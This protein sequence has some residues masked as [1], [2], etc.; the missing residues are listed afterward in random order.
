MSKQKLGE[1]LFGKRRDLNLT[2]K[3]F[4]L[5]FEVPLMFISKLERNKLKITDNIIPQ[6]TLLYG[7]TEAEIRATDWEIDTYDRFPQHLF[8]ITLLIVN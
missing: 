5:Q 7:V 8:P 2:L 1:L 4:C 6:I 3:D